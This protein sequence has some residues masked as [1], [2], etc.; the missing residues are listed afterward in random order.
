MFHKNIHYELDRI[1]GTYL[2]QHSKTYRKFLNNKIKSISKKDF[3]F[4][5]Q[6]LE[7]YT[8]EPWKKFCKIHAIEHIDFSFMRNSILLHCPLYNGYIIVFHP[9]LLEFSKYMKLENSLTNDFVIA[10]NYED[11]WKT[12]GIEPTICIALKDI[13]FRIMPYFDKNI[14]VP[15]FNRNKQTFENTIL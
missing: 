15:N 10:I 1:N 11:T 9:K 5:Y 2:L 4:N 14:K 6:C 13:Y 12:P 8:K 3:L 7:K